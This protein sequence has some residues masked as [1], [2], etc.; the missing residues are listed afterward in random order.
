MV[1]AFFFF[2]SFFFQRKESVE[3][4]VVVVLVI[5]VV[6]VV[7]FQTQGKCCNI[8]VNSQKDSSLLDTIGL[9]LQ[10]SEYR[11]QSSPSWLVSHANCTSVCGLMSISHDPVLVGWL[12]G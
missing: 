4:V 1:L 5:V 2:F 3:I 9:G 12:V 6:V 7:V 10:P 11:P 8:L